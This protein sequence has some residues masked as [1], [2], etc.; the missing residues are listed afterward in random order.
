MKSQT[1]EFL[2]NNPVEQVDHLKWCR[3]NLGTLGQDWNFFTRDFG[4]ILVIE[5]KKEKG[6]VAYALTWD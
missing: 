2:T 1:F 6:I 5:V 3:R 4:K